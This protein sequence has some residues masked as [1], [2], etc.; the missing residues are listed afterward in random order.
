[1]GLASAAM[2]FDTLAAVAFAAALAGAVT[3]LSFGF[4]GRPPWLLGLMLAAFTRAICG[5]AAVRWAAPDA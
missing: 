1:M 2:I 3:R 5:W 4:Q